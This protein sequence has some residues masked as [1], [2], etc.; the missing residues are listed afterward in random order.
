M[1]KKRKPNAG[2]PARYRSAGPAPEPSALRDGLAEHQ[3]LRTTARHTLTAFDGLTEAFD[4]VLDRIAVLGQSGGLD[5]ELAHLLSEAQ[6][7][8]V[9]G[10]D[11]ILSIPDPHSVEEARLLLELE[12]LLKDFAATPENIR[13]WADAE[14]WNRQ[15]KF[16]F[17]RLRQREE[18]RL[19]LDALTVVAARNYWITHSTD[20]HPRPRSHAMPPA[21]HWTFSLLNSMVDLVQPLAGRSRQSSTVC[22]PAGTR[23]PCAVPTES[24]THTFPM[25]S[26][27]SCRCQR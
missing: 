25:R 18:E 21:S 23:N 14:D 5:P 22:R 2:N 13:E 8:V 6:R 11:R 15:S 7:W 27:K 12:Y 9:A 19:G 17:G 26:S 24:S 10:V 1:S 16:G 4:E 3:R 20:S